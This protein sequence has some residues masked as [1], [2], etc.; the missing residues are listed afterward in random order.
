[1]I[2]LKNLEVSMA[3]GS[4]IPSFV[5]KMVMAVVCGV[6]ARKYEMVGG[7]CL[8]SLQR[9]SGDLSPINYQNT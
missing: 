6:A 7:G 3:C 4:G 5:A 9:S 1:M 8:L 2:A